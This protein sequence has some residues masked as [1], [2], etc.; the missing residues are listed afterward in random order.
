ME[1]ARAIKYDLGKR[2][3]TQEALRASVACLLVFE[4]L[5]SFEGF[6]GDHAPSH[7]AWTRGR[8][9]VEPPVEQP[10]PL[11][12]A[13]EI[14]DVWEQ[15][16]LASEP[17]PPGKAAP[18]VR[19]LE[20]RSVKETATIQE[21][22]VP[23]ASNRLEAPARPEGTAAVPLSGAVVLESRPGVAP[24]RSGPVR[25]E[26]P[27]PPWELE[28]ERIERARARGTRHRTVDE[29]R[30]HTRTNRGADVWV[31]RMRVVLQGLT[32]LFVLTS[33]V[34]VGHILLGRSV[35]VPVVSSHYQVYQVAGTPLEDVALSAR[36]LDGRL[37]VVATEAW[38][39][40][41]VKAQH[42]RMQ[43]L[44]QQ[45]LGKDGIEAIVVMAENGRVLAEARGDAISVTRGRALG[46][47]L[48]ESKTAPHG[49]R[50]R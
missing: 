14:I 22:A 17:I 23:G 21:N 5:V 18:T 1:K 31:G 6:R 20:Q 44:A 2:Y 38:S 47:A 24:G 11:P 48:S 19:G 28:A 43:A 16:D 35:P 34:A 32:A 9:P 26:P 13:K 33:A 12:H 8:L 29:R 49:L 37:L 39:A 45:L 36:R 42:A 15:F 3:L 25:K 50:P 40:L 30:R 10:A 4:R 27:P 41:P 46:H 7:K